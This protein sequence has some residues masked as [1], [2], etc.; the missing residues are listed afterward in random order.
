MKKLLTVLVFCAALWSSLALAFTPDKD[1]VQDRDALD[2]LQRDSFRYMWEDA[3]PV[4]G[5]AY[6]ANFAWETRPV[7]VGGTG[8]GIAAIVVAVDRGWITREQ[9]VQRLLKICRFLRDNTN[10]LELHGAFPHWID[11]S[12]GRAMTFSAKDEDADL[13]ETSFLMQGL[14]IARAYFNGPG[15]EETLRASIT[16]LWEGV[17]WNWYTNGE[18]NGIYWHWSP[19]HGFTGLKILGNNECLITYLLALA[20]PTRP[21][22]RKAYD[23][24]TSGKAYKPKDLYGYKVEAALPGAGPL[25]LTHY[26]FIGLDPYRMA[27]AYVPHGYYVRNVK[28]VLSNRSYSLY[29]A[30]AV[31]RYS[32]Q[33]WGLTA[34]QIKGGYNASEPA[35]DVGTIGP[36]GALASMPY[37]PHYS[38]QM[39]SLL[40]GKLRDKA[41]GRFG[42][43]DGISLRDDWVSELYLAIDQLP[44][45]A[46]VENYRSGLLWK[47]FMS[48]PDVRAGLQKA[49][50]SEPVFKT[51]F[52]E[53]VVAVKPKGK[54][55]APDAYETRR[56]PDTGLF[57]IPFWTEKAGPVWFELDEQDGTHIRR[58]DVVARKGR[59][60]LSFEQF[61]RL[62]GSPLVLTMHT[63]GG[64]KHRLPLK[65]Y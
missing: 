5:M 6:E 60:M 62:D 11:S 64:E 18:N 46:M 30:P 16:E 25:F 35:N 15:V 47:L 34:S 13:V 28:H 58:I 42:P 31:N 44:I 10:R 4:S 32:E 55:Y 22:T 8:F 41:W 38:M 48:D 40:R 61:M 51:G 59:N 1:Y 26:S 53:A 27:D 39:L 52:P 7:A 19:K 63:E 12:T 54:G 50:I 33:F 29:H 43:Y 24:W 23:Y 21:I 49:G 45:V 37:T 9:A 65:L 56:H 20:S 14:I 2:A 17:D 36:T 3:D 57:H